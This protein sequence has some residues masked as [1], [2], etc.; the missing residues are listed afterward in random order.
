M[1]RAFALFVRVDKDRLLDELIA[2]LK[3]DDTVT[4]RVRAGRVVPL[5]Q[6]KRAASMSP[7]TATEGRRLAGSVEQGDY[8][9]EQALIES[10]WSDVTLVAGDSLP[11]P[12]SL[13][14]DDIACISVCPLT[15]T[16]ADRLESAMTWAEQVEAA[17]QFDL[18]TPI[19]RQYL[20]S[21]LPLMAMLHEGT[22]FDRLEDTPT[23][24][25]GT[26]EHPEFAIDE[27]VG[28]PSGNDVL[29]YEFLSMMVLEQGKG[30]SPFPQ[31]PA[32]P[33]PVEPL[34]LRAPGVEAIQWVGAYRSTRTN[35]LDEFSAAAAVQ[36]PDI[37][38]RFPDLMATEAKV[39]DYCLNPAHQLKKWTGFESA[40]YRLS[41]PLAVTRLA[42]IINS[43]LMGGFPVA[44]ASVI[45]TGDVLFDVP[46]ALPTETNYRPLLTAWMVSSSVRPKLVTAYVGGDFASPQASSFSFPES[47]V[48][49]LEMFD[50]I[51]EESARLAA[52][53]V[54]DGLS[55]VGV[56]WI[57]RADPRS[58]SF[59]DRYRKD[60][61]PTAHSRVRSKA[62]GRVTPIY[63]PAPDASSVEARIYIV[64][65]ML[66]IQGV[67]AF[68][69]F[70]WD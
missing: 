67:R 49:D 66:A 59:A 1:R 9:R 6:D 32:P 58:K 25:L 44:S 55:A 5:A 31:D 3:S 18:A 17:V 33:S 15:E 11:T 23:D 27:P 30:S 24:F 52:L 70:I 42:G 21:R 16:Q 46:M 54:A 40:G 34:F 29:F 68:A 7:R 37:G 41:D 14:T 50:F 20:W 47:L 62:T 63:V 51:M 61:E 48:D 19:A 8:T 12:N 69:E 36:P 64:Q 28:R 26:D 35:K 39:R 65:A 43:G 38:M 13:L 22:R 57:S 10:M 2:I 60:R 4:A 56:I 53:Y 45:S